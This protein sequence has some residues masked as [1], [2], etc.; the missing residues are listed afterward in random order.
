MRKKDREI[1]DF[2]EIVE[3][4]DKSDV[5]RVAFS[6]ENAVPYIVPFSFGYEVCD[7]KVYFYLHCATEGKK[8]DI[9]RKNPAVCTEIDVFNGYVESPHGITADY[10]SVIGFG[11]IKEVFEEEAVKGIDLLLKH[12]NISGYDPRECALMP[13]TRVLKIEIDEITG[14]KRF[15]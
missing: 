7:N 11:K 13:V 4:I 14:K 5:L 10:K 8:I 3:M 2:D 12:C 6:D 15:K 9:L 1:T